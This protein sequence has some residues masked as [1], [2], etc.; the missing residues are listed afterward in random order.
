M[1]H[2][3]KINRSVA[4]MM[5]LALAI[6]VGLMAWPGHNSAYA[7][8]YEGLFDP[9]S[10][11]TVDIQV[12]P[13]AWEDFLEVATN[14]EYIQVNMRINDH[15]LYSV[16][17]RAKGNSSLNQASG[18]RYS[19]KIEFDHYINGQTLLGLDK[20]VVNNIQ[21]DSTYMK[22]YLAYH[23]LS[24]IG[25]ATSLYAYAWITVNGEPWG[26][27][28]AIEA[29]EESFLMRNYG[30]NYGMLYKPD[31]YQMGGRFATTLERD[32]SDNTTTAFL[33]SVLSRF[34]ESSA[35]EAAAEPE[36]TP[37][38]A[39][40]NAAAARGRG[41]FGGFGGGEGDRLAYTDDKF[42]SYSTIFNSSV[43]TA[44]TDADKARLIDSLRKMNA[45][46][47]LER[48]VDVDAM[49][50]YMAA[51]VMVVNNDSY[52]GTMTHNYY[53]YEKNGRMTM[54]PWDYNLS[55]GGFGGMG[56]GM[57][58]G[59]G[60]GESSASNVVNY[61]IDSVVSGTTLDQRPMLNSLINVDA[62]REQYHDYLYELAQGWAN[63]EIAALMD[64]LDALIGEYVAIDPS[65]FT[66]PEAY[67]A[68][69][70]V[71]KELI[72]L[73]GESILGQL[74]GS[75]P[76]TTQE[77][78]ANANALVDASSIDLSKLGSMGGGNRNGGAGG[79]VRFRNDTQQNA[80]PTGDAPEEAQPEDPSTQGS[81]Q[82]FSFSSLLF[83][84]AKAEAAPTASPAQG[85]GTRG[86]LP[87]GMARPE[88]FTPPEGMT[89]PEGFTPPEGTTLPEG[90]AAPEGAT[91]PGGM[92]EGFTMPEGFALPEGFDANA[93]QNMQRA[94]KPLR[95]TAAS[96]RWNWVCPA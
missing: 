96:L 57:G 16:G 65:S 80:A 22:E 81:A 6:T 56:G 18:N 10:L 61:A 76:S 46:E 3:K 34:Q 53:L 8:A 64:A 86:Q 77:Q 4:A 52:F 35:G 75:V 71:L 36:A 50:R 93:L 66:T 83:G 14:K 17:L 28:L 30:T 9:L 72:R 67:A 2:E 89:L 48:V 33:Q 58:G 41:G 42:E 69:I 60:M 1:P 26:L 79:Q 63:G 43:T 23:T 15:Q 59:G 70:P 21:A 29:L 84:S 38:A 54:L 27:Y 31:T 87:E 74:D 13:Q 95:T 11:L 47:D 92:P 19:F 49:L 24:E 44:P 45:G 7:F 39:Q 82:G 20:M 91:L 68:G 51:N 62:Y 32:P 85:P 55:F 78:S 88:G 12:D 90:T 25:V 5:A 73:R 37:P 40:T 94:R